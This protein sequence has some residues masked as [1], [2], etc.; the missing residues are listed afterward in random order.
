[1]SEEQRENEMEEMTERITQENG[2]MRETELIE[3]EG[4]IVDHSYQP[5]LSITR[6]RKLAANFDPNLVQAI[7]TNTRVSGARAV[8]DGQHRVQAAAIAGYSMLPAWAY[9]GLTIAEEAALFERLNTQRRAGLPQT[10]LFNAK[11]TAGDPETRAI[12][13][14]LDEFGLV[15]GKGHAVINSVGA[16]GGLVWVWQK[17][18]ED[19]LRRAL[20]VLVTA[21]PEDPKRFNQP[22]I[23]AAAL[24]FDTYGGG[25]TRLIDALTKTTPRRVVADIKDYQAATGYGVTFGGDGRMAAPG[26]EVLKREYNKGLHRDSS[27]RIKD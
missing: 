3:I 7:T 12:Q 4:L 11:L 13:T 6:A 17:F 1:M 9:E 25:E 22:L 8:I 5:T 15:V 16:V 14:L 27:N 20:R 19:A 2:T 10:V 21:Y 18:G 23:G 26:A 24:F